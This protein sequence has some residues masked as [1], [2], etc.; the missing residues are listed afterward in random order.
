M[1]KKLTFILITLAFIGVNLFLGIRFFH[2]LEEFRLK[3][4]P[5]SM[6]VVDGELPNQ[7]TL[8]DIDGDKEDEL[9]YG[10][11]DYINPLE[12][13]IYDPLKKEYKLNSS[14]N[15]SIPNTYLFLDLH[16]NNW[17]KTYV[18]KFLERVGE[19]FIIRDIDQHK[20]LLK[21]MSFVHSIRFIDKYSS[22]FEPLGLFDLEGDNRKELLIKLNSGFSRY[23]RGLASYNPESGELLW[24]YRCGPGVWD[25]VIKD[26]DGNGKKEIVFSTFA[27]NNG[28]K[29]NGT[30]DAYSYVIAL[31]SSGKELW[32]KET[33]GWYTLSQIDVTDL[34][35]DGTFEIVTTTACHKVYYKK[36]GKI[37]IFS[38]INGGKKNHYTIT[39][40]SFSRPYAR[41]CGKNKINIFV[42]DS[43]GRLWVFDEDLNYKLKTIKK[44]SPITVLNNSPGGE[45]IHRYLIKTPWPYLTI[46]TLSEL[47][48]YDCDLE[49]K[50]FQYSFERST[51]IKR[52]LLNLYFVAGK[53]EQ[54]N[55]AFLMADK[56]YLISESK[57]SA[58]GFLKHLA[59]SV[60]TFTVIIFFL[61]NGIVF[62]FFYRV[63]NSTAYPSKPTPEILTSHFFATLQEKAHQ[64]KNPISTLLW[65]AEKVKRSS[66]K[67]KNKMSMDKD[68][69]HRL[70]YLLSDDIK[71]MQTHIETILEL[72]RSQSFISGHQPDKDA[73]K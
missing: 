17:S 47:L 43:K 35:N 66:S 5:I 50:L 26:L 1:R 2:Q 24:D 64:L 3:N 6:D 49:K 38:A 56:L 60:L 59:T 12:F 4:G 69:Y 55:Y 20:N 19:K 57:N 52:D 73:E 36:R 54:E 37:F 31:D 25:V 68:S 51:I 15:I 34:D 61:F 21:E 72:I 13:R 30:S 8:I 45:F 58:S 71:I 53:N 63:K 40:A 48:V 65:T 33:G 16:Y 41:K 67:D 44:N 23:P 42:G 70:S 32:K 29:I 9:I 39:D 22:V 46:C 14:K 62:Y 18:F 7:I 10:F 11:Y 28:T 27:L